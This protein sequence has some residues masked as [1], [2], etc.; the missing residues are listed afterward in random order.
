M[1]LVSF[2]MQKLVNLNRSH[3]FISAF[4]S[5]SLVDGQKKKKYVTA[6]Y[7]KECSAYVNLL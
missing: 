3:L 6:I 2:A 5:I 1:F 7:F 4:I